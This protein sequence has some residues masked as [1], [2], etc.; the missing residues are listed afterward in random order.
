LEGNQNVDAVRKRNYVLK[1]AVVMER[2]LF[3]DALF[4]SIYFLSTCIM[5]ASIH[6]NALRLFPD[7]VEWL[8][9]GASAEGKEA[10]LP[11]DVHHAARLRASKVRLRSHA[12]GGHD[13]PPAHEHLL[14]A[15][16]PE[17]SRHAGQAQI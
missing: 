17:T 4:V 7:A 11:G 14:P 1:S 6:V 15:A 5:P 9:R 3:T 10:V 13:L 16:V 12:L 8:D 2:K